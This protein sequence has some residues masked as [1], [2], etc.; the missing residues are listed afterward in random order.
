MNIRG[1]R[2]AIGCGLFL[3]SAAS[4]LTVLEWGR[5]RQIE[6]APPA[7]DGSGRTVTAQEI[8]ERYREPE[9]F[10][11]LIADVR[12]RMHALQ[13]RYLAARHT[14]KARGTRYDNKGQPSAIT[15]TISHVQY[16]DGTEQQT[17][18][19]HRQLLGKPSFFDPEKLKLNQSDTQLL[20]PFAKT[21]PE[22]LYRYRLEGVEELN[23]RR[24]LRI[25]FAPTTAVERSFRGWAWIDPT[26]HEP[27]RLQGVPVKP[28]VRVDRFEMM[29]DY[30][31]SENGHNQL[32]HFTIDAAGGFALM[33]WHFRSETELSD[34]REPET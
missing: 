12:E 14:R 8:E 24:L 19:E 10:T 33:S 22:G 9:T 6:A 31:L 28:R 11:R 13:Q 5:R 20:S 23:G 34:Y 1:K 29:L 18:I 30:G 4:V 15:E 2:Y 25:H 32:R 26:S 21:T 16:R 27:V 7:L 17:E 3:L